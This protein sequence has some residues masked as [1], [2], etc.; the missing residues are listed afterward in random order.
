MVE[1]SVPMVGVSMGGHGRA[2]VTMGGTI[3]GCSGTLG[4]HGGTVLGC[5][6][7]SGVIMGV[8]GGLGVVVLLMLMVPSGGPCCPGGWSCLH[9]RQP[10]VSQCLSAW[11][12]SPYGWSCCH[13]SCPVA[14]PWVATL[15]LWVALVFVQVVVLLLQAASGVT[16]GG[17]GMAMAARS[18]SW[19]PRQSH[20]SPAALSSAQVPP[21]HRCWCPRAAPLSPAALQWWDRPSLSPAS[22]TPWVS[23]ASPVTGTKG[24]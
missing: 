12:W 18:A 6:V 11:Q 5:K 22:P 14:L 15:T 23:P 3:T 13:H 7:T 8:C 10:V 21:S 9:C 16:V 19:L 4:D 20:P 2:V 24:I 17:H 1:L